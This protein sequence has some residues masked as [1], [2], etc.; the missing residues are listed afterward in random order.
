MK[1]SQAFL[2][3]E[4]YQPAVRFMHGRLVLRLLCGFRVCIHIYIY[5]Y[6]CVR[7]YHVR[8]NY[9]TYIVAMSTIDG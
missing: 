5:I 3:A 4:F 2:H 6:M 9:V 8:N 1:S 7:T